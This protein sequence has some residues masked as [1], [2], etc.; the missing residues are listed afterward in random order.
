[1]NERLQK[2]LA[3]A[4]IA[5]RRHS[6]EL[7]A[8]GLVKVNGVVVKELGTKVDLAKDKIEVK[9]KP[10]P[11]TEQKVYYLLNK[12][13][14]YVTTLKDERGRKTVIDLLQGVEERVYP[15]GRLDYDSEGLLLLTNDG[16]LTQA[17][18]HPSHRIK[19]IY[20]ARVEGI[21]AQE[22]LQ[23]M[24]KGLQLED[25]LTSPAEVRLAGT[26]DNRALLEI[27]IHEGR[28]R[29]VRRMCEHIGHPVVRL[30]RTQVGPL[31]LDGL[32]P[33]QFRSLTIKEL[34]EVMALAGIKFNAKELSGNVEATGPKK[35]HRPRA[36]EDGFPRSGKKTL[37]KRGRDKDNYPRPG[38]D[39]DTASQGRKGPKSFN[40]FDGTRNKQGTG[41]P[42]TENRG[43]DNYP[44]PGAGK[45]T[46]PR[47]RKGP[48]NFNSFSGT[49]NKQGTGRS[50]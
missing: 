4:G 6:E 48:K 15:V 44:R 47:D 12:P 3:R 5:S 14:G 2:I 46:V 28:N 50:K 27:I 21:P 13:R 40:S 30:Q 9:G 16:E 37:P 25:G 33:G 19:K 22:K 29:Q 34:K 38:A 35:Y 49:R 23:A 1:M 42:N 36:V 8:Q 41:Q 31:V 10:L 17:L 26:R 45:D 39:R 32:K 20:L 43:R 24:A 7:I 18:T 11:Q